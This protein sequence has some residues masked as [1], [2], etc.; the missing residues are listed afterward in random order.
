MQC[1]HTIDYP[2]PIFVYEMD[3]VV[4]VFPGRESEDKNLILKQLVDNSDYKLVDHSN[5]NS[6]VIS[7]KVLTKEGFTVVAK[8]RTGLLYEFKKCG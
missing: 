2:K 5:R 4:F 6:R 7:S 3:I 1:H 8:G